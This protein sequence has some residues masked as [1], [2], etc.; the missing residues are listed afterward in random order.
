MLVCLAS[1][2][3]GI[4]GCPEKKLDKL[5]LRTAPSQNSVNRRDVG[6]ILV[7][8]KIRDANRIPIAK[9]NLTDRILNLRGSLVSGI[10]HV[11]TVVQRLKLRHRRGKR[12]HAEDGE[13]RIS[14]AVQN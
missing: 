4:A 1:H 3:D 12:R 6:V 13:Q 9:K 2:P 5:L 10:A 14:L 7:C 11:K 8:G